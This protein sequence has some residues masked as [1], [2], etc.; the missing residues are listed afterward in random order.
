M[1][2]K[3]HALAAGIF[4]L[5]V[6]AMLA[7]LAGFLFATKTGGTN[8]DLLSWHQS[9]MVLLMLILGGTGRLGGA[10]LGATGFILLQELYSTE[11]LVGRAADNWQLLVGVTMIVL[12]ALLPRGLVGLPALLRGRH[13]GGSDGH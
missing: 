3:S 2:N 5:V 1:E 8:P 9:G 11:A 7:G 13:A 4:V 10:V 6:A 12:V